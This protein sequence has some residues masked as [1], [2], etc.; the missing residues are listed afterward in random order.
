MISKITKQLIISNCFILFIIMISCTRNNEII[1]AEP[2]VDCIE[3]YFNSESYVVTEGN[4]A[5]IEVYL[6]KPS[7]VPIFVPIT[8][9]SK[10]GEVEYSTDLLSDHY[11]VISDGVNSE[12]FR[13]KVSSD[14]NTSD[15]TLL[16]SFDELPKGLIASDT[17]PKSVDIKISDDRLISINNVEQLNAIRYDMDGNGKVD[18]DANKSLYTQAF[19]DLSSSDNFKGY[20][21]AQDIKVNNWIPIGSKDKPFNT[22][23]H[24]CNHVLSKVNIN[25]GSISDLAL[26]SFIGENGIVRNLGLTI[27]KI[28]GGGINAAGLASQ[29]YGTIMNCYVK[30]EKDNI[31]SNFHGVVGGLVSKNYGYIITSYTEGL[32]IKSGSDGAG[33]VGVNGDSKGEKPDGTIIG[34]YALNNEMVYNPTNPFLAGLVVSNVGESIVKACYVRGGFIS[35]HQ[36]IRNSATLNLVNMTNPINCYT[37]DISAR[38]NIG[39]VE[40]NCYVESTIEDVENNVKTTSQLKSPTSYTG[41]YANWL[42]DIDGNLPEHITSLTNASLPN[43]T[44]VDDIWDFGNQNNYPRLKVDFNSDGIATSDE[45][46][47]Q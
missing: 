16:L 14:E 30:G 5:T 10:E 20:K 1:I 6:S 17:L 23:F 46:G 41:V 40:G 2:N 7:D 43:N 45:F 24:G 47:N 4:Y 13:I 29:N 36:Y 15:E 27:A 18:D 3:V 37:A 38:N 34:C 44:D 12:T 19:P 28:E 35:N 11:L 31:V 21:L 32:T 26:F 33:L 25:V 42:I 39:N 8:I 9:V 22:L